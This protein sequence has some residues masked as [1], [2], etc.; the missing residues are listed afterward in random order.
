MSCRSM[1]VRSVTCGAVGVMLLALQL[2]AVPAEAAKPQPGSEDLAALQK[3]L[4]SGDRLLVMGALGRIGGEKI[5]PAGVLIVDFIKR[6]STP[7]LLAAAASA[8][9]QL[10]DRQLAEAVAPLVH[11]RN[12]EVSRS[13]ARALAQL[14]GA[15][16][17]RALREGLRGPDAAVRGI[18]AGGLGELGAR[19][20]LP[21]L[22]LAFERNIGEAATAIGQVC[23]PTRCKEFS[24]RLG[25]AP[26][27]LVTSGIEQIL[28]RPTQEIPEQLKVEII[29]HLAALRTNEVHRYLAELRQRWPDEWGEPL[30]KA[31][32]RA[33]KETGGL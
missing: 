4:A 6:G 20:A 15:A 29:T 8:A 33:I 3:Q 31:L 24:E 16:S 19:D 1:L 32:D 23:D 22:I 12:A 10:N 9:S 14:G 30:R 27:A 5:A 18:C 26:F 13:A 17:I 25:K 2:Q 21:D 7:E 11:H 28:F